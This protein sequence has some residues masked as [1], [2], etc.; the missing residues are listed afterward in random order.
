MAILWLQGDEGKPA[1]TKETL[2]LASCLVVGHVEQHKDERPDAELAARLY[3]ARPLS[4]ST[5]ELQHDGVD[6]ELATRPG[7][8][9]VPCHSQH[10]TNVGY[11]PPTCNTASAINCPISTSNLHGC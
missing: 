6:A 3:T 5:V 4:D 8:R 10:T 2:Y 7:G 1:M 11:V 9:G